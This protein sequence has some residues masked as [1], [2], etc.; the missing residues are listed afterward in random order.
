MSNRAIGSSDQ[1]W[2]DIRTHSTYDLDAKGVIDMT[3]KKPQKSVQ[4]PKAHPARFFLTAGA[5]D[6]LQEATIANISEL[7][8]LQRSKIAF[9][10]E[11]LITDYE[12]KIDKI[13]QNYFTYHISS[14][15]RLLNPDG[16]RSYLQDYIAGKVPA[17]YPPTL[18]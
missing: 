5:I 9:Y 16:I 3:G 1:R 4:L 11:Q 8:G 10:I 2:N 13:G 12:M 15:G 17:P 6:R 7:T 18:Q 14:W